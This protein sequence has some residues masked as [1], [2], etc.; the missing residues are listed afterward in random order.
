MK[1]V[2]EDLFTDEDKVW[3]LRS[4]LWSSHLFVALVALLKPVMFVQESIQ[5]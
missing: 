3:V 2:G 4:T 1:V 5:R